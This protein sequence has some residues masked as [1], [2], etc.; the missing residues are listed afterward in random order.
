MN[1][2][3]TLQQM[4]ILL[5]FIAV[6]LFGITYFLVFQKNMNRAKAYDAET[7][8]VKTQITKI[9]ALQ[10]Q[11]TDMEIYNSRYEEE[12]LEYA[13]SFPVKLTRQKAIYMLHRLQL[14]ADVE[15]Q[16]VNV[17]NEFPF[18]YKGRLL[19]TATEQEEAKAENAAEPMSELLVKESM[20]EM[21]GSMATYEINITGTTE[22]VYKALDWIT[23]NSEKL[24]IGD[25]NLQFDSSTGK[26]NGT[27]GVNFYCMLGN[28]VPY[29]E[30]DTKS[31]TFGVE[32][33]IFGGVKKK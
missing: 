30:P 7:E 9:E 16:S 6:V 17:G 33:D 11:I 19:T 2:K 10:P 25:V 15:I 23:E 5:I 1:G 27:I 22:Q 31:F 8:S 26:L 14:H 13:K 3:L 29:K 21:I 4:R 20:D 24:S 12:M 32:G 18:Y 28:G